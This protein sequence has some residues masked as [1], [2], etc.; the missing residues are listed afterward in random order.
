MANS[1]SLFKKFNSKICLT[2]SK[3]EQL[4]SSKKALREKIK[5][6]FDQNHPNHPIK[7][8]SQGSLI[9]GT[10]LNPILKS[11]GYDLD[12]GIYFLGKKPEESVHT[13][14]NWVEKAVE[15][16]TSI[17]ASNKNPCIRVFYANDYHV[18]LPIYYKEEGEDPYLAHK[19]EGW[20]LSDPKAFADW[21]QEKNRSIGNKGQL[22]RITR[23]LKSWR[24]KEKGSIPCGFVLSI[25]AAENFIAKDR[26]DQSFYETV[27]KTWSELAGNF[28]CFRPTVPVGEDLLEEY[29][30]NQK[31]DFLNRLQ[32]L[33]E[34]GERAL[35]LPNYR[36][37]SRKWRK[38][39]GDRFPQGEDQIDPDLE[40]E[41]PSSIHHDARSA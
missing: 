22:R 18:D 39:F 6:H 23:Y 21:Y 14:H 8:T 25:L 2:K 33:V 40:F 27:K 1:H 34:D 5:N 11:K 17:P 16:H 4:K 13:L 9:L 29:T 3:K 26:D 12:D 19:E 38:H 35:N 24:A 37:A 15:D 30:E 41:E 7:F 32:G 28:S 20:I 10:I 36:E 31:A